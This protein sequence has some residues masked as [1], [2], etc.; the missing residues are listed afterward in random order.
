MS[1]A[2]ADADM[3]PE[4]IDYINAHGTSTHMNDSC[5]TKAGRKAFGS[6]ADKLMVSSTKSMTGHM[7]D[8][9]MAAIIIFYMMDKS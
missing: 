1:L 9:R 6:W 7:L 2:L 5:E 4:D 3:R 8:Q